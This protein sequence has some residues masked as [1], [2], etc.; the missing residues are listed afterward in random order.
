[1]IGKY[2]GA[3]KLILLPVLTQVLVTGL[4]TGTA[5]TTVGNEMAI[6]EHSTK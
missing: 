1:M 2:I 3:V 6:G 4:P 5:A